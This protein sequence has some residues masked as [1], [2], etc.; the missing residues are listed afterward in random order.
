MCS[1]AGEINFK[2]G[3][4]Y[5]GRE[6]GYGRTDRCINYYSLQRPSGTFKNLYSISVQ[7]GKKL[8]NRNYRS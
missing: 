1:I 3:F 7:H 6:K 8:K 5:R 4:R 2:N